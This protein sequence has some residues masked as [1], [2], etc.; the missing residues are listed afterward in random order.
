MA[1]PT[2]LRGTRV[3]NVGRCDGA[4]TQFD[5]Q[6]AADTEFSWTQR[7]GVGQREGR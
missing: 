6:S 3:M 5:W 2:R 1:T 4:L 7:Q